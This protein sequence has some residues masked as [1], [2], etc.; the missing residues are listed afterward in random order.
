VE[1]PKLND[2]TAA[3]VDVSSEGG[4]GVGAEDPKLNPDTGAGA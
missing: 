2:D 4:A 3:L 1:L